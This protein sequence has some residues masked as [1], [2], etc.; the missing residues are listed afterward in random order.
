MQMSGGAWYVSSVRL[1]P[2]LAVT[3]I[4]A[5]SFAWMAGLHSRKK[6]VRV[7]YIDTEAGPIRTC[8]DGVDITTP[9]GKGKSITCPRG[10]YYLRGVDMDGPTHPN[11]P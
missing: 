7:Y 6:T 8:W 2:P 5:A 9:N 11:K 3:G 1:T 10:L 4:I